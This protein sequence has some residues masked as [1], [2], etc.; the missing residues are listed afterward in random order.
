MGDSKKIERYTRLERLCIKYTA[1]IA[2]IFFI[3]L[4]IEIFHLKTTSYE[5]RHR[6]TYPDFAFTLA[7]F[8]CL[9][10]LLY[11]LSKGFWTNY[12]NKL[13]NKFY[14]TIPLFTALVV[15][16]LL[17]WPELYTPYLT[18]TGWNIIHFLGIILMFFIVRLSNSKVERIKIVHKKNKI[19][20]NPDIRFSENDIRI[21]YILTLI[22]VIAF[23]TFIVIDILGTYSIINYSFIY[24]NPSITNPYFDLL[25][26]SYCSVICLFF[27]TIK[28]IIIGF[29]KKLR[30]IYICKLPFIILI[31]IIYF[32]DVLDSLQP[33]Y[34]VLID[35]ASLGFF[36]CYLMYLPINE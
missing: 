35:A 28:G 36:I 16:I 27:F 23:S 14:Y 13:N 15:Y 30:K 19:E 22:C 26:I 12:K 5:F 34:W 25:L 8:T 11:F 7:L 31:L 29:K 33:I 4:T 9:I 3:A 10:I 18:R 24:S 20:E 1:A 2:I 17:Y 21:L 6:F 32:P